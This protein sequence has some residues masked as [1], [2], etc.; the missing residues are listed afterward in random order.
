MAAQALPE[1]QVTMAGVAL[2]PAELEQG[3]VEVI[4]EGLPRP[5]WPYSSP[6]RDCGGELARPE[7][8]HPSLSTA[9]DWGTGPL[10][11][12]RARMI[13]TP[14]KPHGFGP[15]EKCCFTFS[16]NASLLIFAQRICPRTPYLTFL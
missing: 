12:I 5:A 2:Q 1:D 8:R 15:E 3:S 11:P 9:E 10:L 4:A 14:N 7:H 6:S 16:M 13:P